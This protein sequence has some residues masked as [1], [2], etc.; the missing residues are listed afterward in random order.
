V[1]YGGCMLPIREVEGF[2]ILVD[3][4]MGVWEDAIDAAFTAVEVSPQAPTT[5]HEKGYAPEP[6]SYPEVAR[7]SEPATSI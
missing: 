1:H 7:G 5:R 4:E 2:T 3:E 6:L